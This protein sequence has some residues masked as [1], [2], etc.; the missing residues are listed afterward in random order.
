MELDIR[1]GKRILYKLNG[2]WNVGELAQANAYVDKG[3]FLPVIKKEDLYNNLDHI[4]IEIND[5]FLEAKPVESWMQDYGYLM[6]KEQ[7]IDFINSEDFNKNTEHAYVSDGEYYYYS[8]NK[9]SEQWL[10]KQPFDY[11]V[12][13]E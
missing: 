2:K 13:E 5:I 9:Y 7:Y 12:R 8:I 6:T 3:L 4:M 11:V 1:A 10:N